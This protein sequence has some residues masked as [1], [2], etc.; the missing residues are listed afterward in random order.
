MP[1]NMLVR[2]TYGSR[3]HPTL[4][5]QR[6]RIFWQWPTRTHLLAVAYRTH[7]LAVAY[8][9][10]LLAVAYRTHHLA[11]AYRR[12]LLAVA[13]RTHLLAVAYRTHLGRGLQNT[14]WHWSTEHI[15]AVAYRTH[16]G[17]GLQNTSWQWPTE[18]TSGSHVIG[19]DISGHGSHVISSHAASTWLGSS[20]TKRLESLSRGQSHG[21]AVAGMIYCW[22]W[23][24]VHVCAW[25]A[26]Q[27]SLSRVFSCFFSMDSV[28]HSVAHIKGAP[29]GPPHM[30]RT[31]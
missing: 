9:T 31:Q 17:I 10:H 20:G 1:C 2:H 3:R 12:H 18:H 7:L 24:I 26:A 8:R 28:T 6:G 29:P 14:S 19:H 22:L 16:L 5:S 25:D 13:Y 15:L 30:V 23:L 21:G 11:V 27:P 4:S